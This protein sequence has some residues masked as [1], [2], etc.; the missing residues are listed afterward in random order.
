[1][2]KSVRFLVVAAAAVSFG[3][4]TD[5][6]ASQKLSSLAVSAFNSAVGTAIDI[7]EAVC[8]LASDRANF[9]SG[10][11]LLVDGGYGI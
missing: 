2:S 7:A 1:V 11:H 3:T 9:V 6:A 5:Q 10:V 8:F 4:V